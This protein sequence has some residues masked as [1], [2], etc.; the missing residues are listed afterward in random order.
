M[1]R[2][3]TVKGVGLAALAGL[4]LLAA[5]C[6]G[7]KATDSG[8]KRV[9]TASDA[10]DYFNVNDVGEVKP[11]P[12]GKLYL[13]AQD[14]LARGDLSPQSFQVLLSNP[15]EGYIEVGDWYIP[16]SVYESLQETTPYNLSVEAMNL[17]EGSE[18]KFLFTAT[19]DEVRSVLAKLGLS[20]RDVRKLSVDG[21]L[22]IDDLRTLAS[23]A[24]ERAAMGG[25]SFRAT[26][27]SRIAARQGR[28]IR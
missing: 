18:I 27:E 2:R 14:I 6:S 4:A 25:R 28:D 15:N 10:L 9:M 3:R 22:S 5:G 23:L 26:L 16:L 20:V 19:P 12:K 7:Q 24:D 1:F 8:G 11:L 13:T 21:E 17:L